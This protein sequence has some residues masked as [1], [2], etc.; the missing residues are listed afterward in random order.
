MIE[1]SIV[2][3]EAVRG[4]LERLR[5]VAGAP[6]E[7][8]RDIGIVAERRIK[9]CFGAQTAPEMG[10]EGPGGKGAAAMGQPWAALAMETIE[11]RRKGKGKGGGVKI[12]QDTDRLKMSIASIVAGGAVT[13]GTGINYG[14]FHQGGTARMP[15]RP[16]VGI[17]EEDRG[18]MVQIVMRHL[19]AAVR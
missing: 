10:P 14:P 11:R 8:A 18:T 2:G 13:V 1:V 16:F 3:V 12:L 15:A 17:N 7:I 4:A 6:D 5:R 19:E 9:R